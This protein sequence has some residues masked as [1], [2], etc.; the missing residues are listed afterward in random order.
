MRSEGKSDE[1]SYFLNMVGGG[2][3]GDEESG[4]NADGKNGTDETPFRPLLA[5]KMARKGFQSKK[6]GIIKQKMQFI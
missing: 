1:S 4:R 5:Q 6:M 2:Q 3:K